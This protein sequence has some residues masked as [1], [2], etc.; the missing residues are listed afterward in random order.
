MIVRAD[1]PVGVQAAMIIHAAGLASE[2]ADGACKRAE[3]NRR[4]ERPRERAAYKEAGG[5]GCRG[6]LS[7][8]PGACSAAP[9]TVIIVRRCRLAGR[10]RVR[11]AVALLASS[12][13]ELL[14]IARALDD[15]DLPHVLVREP[16]E[17]YRND[18][19]AAA[20]AGAG[21]HAPMAI[22]VVP[23][24]RVRV[25]RHLAHLPLVRG[26]AKELS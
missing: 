8:L 7:Q 24:P 3:S 22:G 13:D 26:L 9:P 2:P 16:D 11:P 20:A 1:V 25:R 23:M 10:C 12:V 6:R 19:A 15:A 21:R 17:P 4:F 5:R 18:P 14:A